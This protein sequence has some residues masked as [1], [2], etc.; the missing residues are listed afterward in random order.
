MALNQIEGALQA[1][2]F[3]QETSAQFGDDLILITG[4]KFAF[5]FL[6]LIVPFKTQA[7]KLLNSVI[8]CQASLDNKCLHLHS[9]ESVSYCFSIYEI[10]RYL[11]I[12]NGGFLNEAGLPRYLSPSG[13]DFTLIEIRYIA[14]EIEEY[15]ENTIPMKTHVE[16]VLAQ[17]GYN[18]KKL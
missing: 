17:L 15:K 3:M 9:E 14:K 5:G 11:S 16:N 13:I 18:A 4:S 1:I 10:I 2:T 7:T 8:A 12:I 6:S